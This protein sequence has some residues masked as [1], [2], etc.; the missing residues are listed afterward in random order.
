[1]GAETRGSIKILVICCRDFPGQSIGASY[2][3]D[4]RVL[5]IRAP[6]AFYIGQ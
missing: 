6:G 5:S 1:V 2:R 3:F 4:R